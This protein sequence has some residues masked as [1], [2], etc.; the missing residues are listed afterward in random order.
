MD[1][2]GIV[3]AIVGI[4]I[5]AYFG[6]RSLFQS[7]DM[8]ALQ[9][10]LRVHSQATFN[11]LYR[12]GDRCNVLLQRD[13]LTIETREFVTGFNETSIAARAWIVAFS[14]EHAQ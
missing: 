10:A 7:N 6:L 3:L 9:R 11:H 5:G 14:R 1:V 2:V 12:I 13:N 8:E 4:L